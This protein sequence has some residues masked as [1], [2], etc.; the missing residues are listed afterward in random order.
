MGSALGE[1]LV[2]GMLLGAMLGAL[3]FLLFFD[4]LFDLLVDLLVDLGV[5]DVGDFGVL[6]DDGDLGVLGEVG[7]LPD[8]NA[9]VRPS[10]AA[11]PW[12]KRQAERSERRI[13]ARMMM[14]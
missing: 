5:L 10:P 12:R 2:L 7:D 13:E 1:L 8:F 9:R 14:I 4:L 11:T 6:E 3:L